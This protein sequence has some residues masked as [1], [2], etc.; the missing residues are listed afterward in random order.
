[1]RYPVGIKLTTQLLLFQ[2]DK[3]AN[4][5]TVSRCPIVFSYEWKKNKGFA[6]NHFTANVCDKNLCFSAI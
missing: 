6:Y 4:Y 2:R 3:I 5:Y 1:M